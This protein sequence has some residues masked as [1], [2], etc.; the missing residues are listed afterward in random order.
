MIG[1][2][3]LAAE[4]DRPL[5]ERLQ[6][7]VLHV[8]RFYAAHPEV[9]DFVA[10][11]GVESPER[12]TLVAERLLRPAYETV[13]ELFAAGIEAGFIRSSHPA[14]FFALL[15]SAASQP[16]AFPALLNQLAPEIDPETA[17]A[18]MVET[19]IATL[20]HRP[21]ASLEEDRMP[22][23]AD[24]FEFETTHDNAS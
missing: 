18:R 16:P 11:H 24:A 6:D 1:V 13:R 17:R 2:A 20:L 3:K 21:K 10:R 23:V 12:A 22:P 9:R 19:I 15:N 5:G 8:A 14:L 7:V 4:C